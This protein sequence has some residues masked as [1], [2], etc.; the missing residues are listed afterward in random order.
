MSPDLK[1]QGGQAAAAL[2][3]LASQPGAH[4]AVLW[5][6]GDLIP[7][8]DA[9]VH[10]TAV[11]H[12]SVSSVFEGI[13]AYRGDDGQLLAFRLREHMKRFANSMRICR[14]DIPYTVD[15]MRD[16]V[17]ELLRANKVHADT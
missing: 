14:L 7:W 11:G 6:N 13:K 8:D 2:S 5:R 16:A 10:I 17:G 3:S 4:G 12:A 1:C 9:K 15:Q